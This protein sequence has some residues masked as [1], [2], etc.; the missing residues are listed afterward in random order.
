ME[1]PCNE[2]SEPV[3]DMNFSGVLHVISYGRPGSL[4]DLRFVDG[5]LV[6]IHCCDTGA[7]QEFWPVIEHDSGGVNRETQLL[8]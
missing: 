4:Y 5:T 8:G 3:G 2:R 1:R 6:E 7:S